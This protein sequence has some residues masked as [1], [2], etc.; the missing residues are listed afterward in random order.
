MVAMIPARMCQW[1]VSAICSSRSGHMRMVLSSRIAM[2][3]PTA[4]TTKFMKIN[5]H[6][7]PN[8]SGSCSSA[9]SFLPKPGRSIPCAASRARAVLRHPK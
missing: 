9:V 1:P 3:M 8:L 7:M 5:C 2:K 4:V 6:S